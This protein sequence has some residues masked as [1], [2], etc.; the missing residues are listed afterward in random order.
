MPEENVTINRKEIVRR[1][2]AINRGTID[3][4]LSLVLCASAFVEYKN[5]GLDFGSGG[6]SLGAI[7][8]AYSAYQ[9]L[10]YKSTSENAFLLTGLGL[11]AA[12]IENIV[13]SFS[14]QEHKADMI[15]GTLNLVGA[16]A[17]FVHYLFRRD[18]QLKIE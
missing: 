17:I 8:L 7:S 13:R 1:N 15:V 6:Y 11:T 16:G 12:G 14:G 9:N 10:K 5:S 3:T 18:K 4:F 2:L